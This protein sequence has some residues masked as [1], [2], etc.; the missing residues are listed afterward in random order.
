[1]LG[2]AKEEQALPEIVCLRG[3][4]WLRERRRRQVL[5]VDLAESLLALEPRTMLPAAI[6]EAIARHLDQKGLQLRRAGKA[7]AGAAEAVE[8]I[9]PCRLHNIDGIK[10][11]TQPGRELAPD[12]LPEIG[13]VGDKHSPG[14][15]H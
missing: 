3:Q 6:D 15:G 11:R 10:A 9:A 13:L 12:Y 4:A 1:M 14:R 7:P 5:G 8:Q 2:R